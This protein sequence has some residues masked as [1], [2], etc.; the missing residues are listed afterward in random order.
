MIIWRTVPLT[1]TST[2]VTA[3]LSMAAIC[4]FT[5]PVTLAL[6]MGA[7]MLTVGGVVSPGMVMPVRPQKSARRLTAQMLL[8]RKYAPV[9]PQLACGST[10]VPWP[11]LGMRIVS[12]SVVPDASW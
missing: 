11:M 2:R 10:G 5:E 8:S 12:T 6:F 3:V 7:V 9:E 1:A 4:T